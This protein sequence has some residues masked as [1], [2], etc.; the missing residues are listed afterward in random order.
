M[1]I[2]TP[3]VVVRV[4]GEALGGAIRQKPRGG[5]ARG[6]VGQLELHGL[7]LADGL[8]EGG[9][10]LGVAKRRLEGRLGEA[11][12]GRGEREPGQDL[13]GSRRSV[14]EPRRS[15]D[16]HAVEDHVGG[17]EPA[18]AECRG[19]RAHGQMVG[20]PLDHEAGGLAVGHPREH[21]EHV[22]LLGMVHEGRGAG[23]RPAIAVGARA[24]PGAERDRAP[25]LAAG[26]RG[27]RPLSRGPGSTSAPRSAR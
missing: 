1:A 13:R 18:R 3:A 25:P 22:A 9:P 19:C 2:R 23:E 20:I 21:H 10:L 14:A 7:V 15:A 5:D 11:H 6:H 24:D 4:G 16:P 8:A 27:Q 17:A 26:H 12:R